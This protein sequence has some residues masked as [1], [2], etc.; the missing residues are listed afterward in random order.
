VALEFARIVEENQSMVFSIALR[1]LRDRQGAE[2]LAQD[3]FLQLY[4]QLGR[5]ESPAH[6]TWWLRRA[7]CHRSI[8]EVRKRNLR[9]RVGLESVPEP[10][11]HEAQPDHLLRDRLR[12]LVGTLPEKARAVVLLRYQEDLDPGEIAEILEMPV[13]TVKSHL[14]R[15]L[16]VLRGKLRYREVCSA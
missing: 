3:V 4:Q 10:A 6:A 8:D 12:Q 11:S 5:I 15:S 9:P 1:Y 7:I 13:S 2:E 14:H 16:A